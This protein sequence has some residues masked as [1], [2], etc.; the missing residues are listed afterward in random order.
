[1][2][3]KL[4]PRS[5]SNYDNR[6]HGRRESSTP[7]DDKTI[8][9]TLTRVNVIRPKWAGNPL[10]FRAFPAL[11]PTKT[12]PTPLPG[13][14][15]IEPRE[16]NEFMVR[17][18]IASYVGLNTQGSEK[19]TFILY[20]P[21]LSDE[22]RLD[23][24][25][26]VFYFACK[27]AHKAG[28]FGNGRSWDGRWNPLMIGARGRGPEIGN[29][30]ARW[31]VQGYVLANDEKDYVA[32]R[33]VPM[34]L[35]DD[36]DTVLIQLSSSA[37]DGL[38][39]L[40]STQ[41][42]PAKIPNNVDPDTHPWRFLTYGDPTGVPNEDGTKLSKG[43]FMTVFNPNRVKTITQHT[44]W[45]GTI[46][47]SGQ[48]YEAA[49]SRQWTSSNKKVLSADMDDAAL[50]KAKEA[51]QF[52]FDDPATGQKGLLR[53]PSMEEQCL[54]IAKGY[55]DIPELL[56][57]AWSD[58]P[59]FM[60]SDVQAVLKARRSALVPDGAGG[61]GNGYSNPNV[62]TDAS[63]GSAD[64]FQDDADD[65]DETDEE[66][67]KASTNKSQSEPTAKVDDLDD[68]EDFDAEEEAEASLEADDDA[69]G[70][71][72]DEFDEENAMESPVPSAGS[73]A[74]EA[75][76]FDE[77]DDLDEAPAVA[78]ADSEAEMSAAMAAA[79]AKSGK[80]KSKPP[81]A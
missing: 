61:D 57:F 74:E 7:P 76:E 21:W 53:V 55:K 62:Q 15:G 22:K 67:P 28:Q 69:F 71:D 44:S 37:G 78:A 36:D 9:Q 58:H 56:E 23:N 60:T 8:N 75:D 35:G 4:T 79:K 10:T 63:M 70:D 80:R 52:W 47:E 54:M 38:L 64:D 12:V 59:E 31:Y 11:D 14:M 66:T 43:V 24:P 46:K 73:N 17:V 29:P 68:E 77:D 42:P 40:L 65:F 41:R 50:A 13:R 48:G 2:P 16:V 19:S 81:K 20:E 26:R 25:Y 1:M 27:D 72:P 3:R 51:W 34:G 33:D 5:A 6:S 18:P 30:S 32:E 39:D 45:D 49:I